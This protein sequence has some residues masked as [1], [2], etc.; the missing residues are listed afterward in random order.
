MHSRLALA[1]ALALAPSPALAQST[2]P[3]RFD[4]DA[5][6]ADGTEPLTADRAVQMAVERS[7]RIES[8]RA[9]A[10]A[11]EASVHAATTALVPRLDLGARYSHIDGFPDGQISGPGGIGFSIHIP[12]DQ[13]AFTARLTIP[14]SDFFFAGLP[15]LDGA[16]ARVRAEHTRVDAAASDVALT[17]I[18][19]FYQ[20]I[21]ARGV[22]AVATSARDN[23]VATRDQVVR[24]AEAGI[25]GPAD[26]ASAEARVAQAEEALARAD[27]AVD[28]SGGA[29][30]I[31]IGTPH[32]RRFQVAAAI[33][34][35]A[36][37]LPGTLDSIETS[38]LDHR[39]EIRA[40]RESIASQTHMRDAALG[41]AYP[42]IAVY[43]YAEESNPNPRIIPPSQTWN[44]LWELGATLT[45]SPNDTATAVFRSDELSA[46]IQVAE[47]Q[48]HV[49]EDGVRLEVRQAYEELRASARSLEAAR[50][51]AE[52]AEEA[53]R[54]Q[55][56]ELGAGESILNDILLADARATEA[57]LADLRARI[58]AHRARARL[59]H[60]MGEAVDAAH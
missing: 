21:E 56:A 51:S 14:I 45:W 47:D 29:L 35:E 34:S 9:T 33:P 22:A 54:A 40:L 52:A 2:T 6:L 18:E 39:P 27:A 10:A 16:E 5:A 49:L 26:R 7:P 42:H 28:V 13:G 31:L 48:M 57:R 53:Y 25:L 44:P 43:G 19:A 60:A 23:A 46:Q 15:A 24:Y 55:V 50:V 3:T 4:L 8:A 11:A 17:T 30:S 36:P 59:G 32:D 38:A 1:L 41:G 58:T 12:R 37:A 20:Y